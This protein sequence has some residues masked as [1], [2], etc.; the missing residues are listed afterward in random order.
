MTG[1]ATA[2]AATNGLQTNKICI[3]ANTDFDSCTYAVN[4]S[5]CYRP[6]IINNNIHMLTSSEIRQGGIYLD[7]S[8]GYTV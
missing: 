6:L 5:G 7:N 4:L 3:V 8:T 1:F 2:V